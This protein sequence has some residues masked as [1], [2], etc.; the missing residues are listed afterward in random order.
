MHRQCFVIMPFS[1]TTE[2]HTEA[3]WTRFFETYLRPT[4]TNIGYA[5]KRSSAS[6]SSIIKG[7]LEQL[8]SSDLVLAVLTD[9]NPNVWYELGTRHAL[10]SGTVMII[11]KGQTLP[12]DIRNHGVIEYEDTIEG[13]AIFE[14]TLRDFVANCEKSAPLDSPARDFFAGRSEKPT[15][16]ATSLDAMRMFAMIDAA[17]E[18]VFIAGQNLFLLTRPAYHF[19][20]KLFS[21]LQSKAVRVD[22]LICDNTA[23]HSVRALTD[24]TNTDFA[25]DLERAV[26]EFRQWDEQIVAGKFIGEFNV[27]LTTRI[28]TLTMVFVDPQLESGAAAM[29]P[30]L[31]ETDAHGRPCFW[32]TRK[33]HAA[34]FD[35]YF[36][37]YQ[38]VF[39]ASS[40]TRSIRA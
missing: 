35:L 4:V 2:I 32:L 20:E 36:Q 28:G 10:R 27:R 21:L 23:E 38:T 6:T 1:Q 5:C 18:R 34:I 3:Y 22:L 9:Y 33:D 25:E 26:N 16:I 11:E 39:D 13:R 8:V 40:K 29:I 7:I 12:F 14:Q 24:F 17:K 37:K 19:K 31:P 15:W 30:V